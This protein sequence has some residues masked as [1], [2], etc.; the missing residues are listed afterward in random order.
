MAEGSNPSH[1]AV[2]QTALVQ[3]VEQHNKRPDALFGDEGYGLRWDK[4]SVVVQ[5]YCPRCQ[6]LYRVADPH[7][8]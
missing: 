2:C 3:V 6:L 7:A 8:V 4:R 5:I 1:C